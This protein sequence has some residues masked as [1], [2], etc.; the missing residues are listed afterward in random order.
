MLELISAGAREGPVSMTTVE[1]AKKLEKS[2]QMASKHLEEMEEEGLIERMRSQ[3]KT[4]I[5]LTEKGNSEALGLYSSLDAAF[6]KT[7]K[8]ELKGTIFSGLGEGAYYISL[9]G[10]SK[11][12]ESKLGFRP[13]PGTLN[14]RLASSI[15]RSIRSD[16]EVSKGIHI[17]GFSDG[18]R[19][20]GG[21]ECFRALLNF[22]IHCAVLFIERTSHDDSVVEVIAPVNV[23]KALKLKEES[24]VTLEVYLDEPNAKK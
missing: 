8:V 10:Y 2:Q 18:K 16:L 3:G 17:E 4:F 20:F 11:Q 13:H 21:A 24:Q 12:F 19:T 9:P 15:E 23:R 22:Q 14:I 1:L 5:K 6:R 7:K